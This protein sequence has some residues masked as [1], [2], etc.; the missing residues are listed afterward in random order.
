M[1][2]EKNWQAWEYQCHIP[3]HLELENMQQYVVLNDAS[4]PIGVATQKNMVLNAFSEWEG[5]KKCRSTHDL[6]HEISK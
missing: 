1:E 5:W 6:K 2:Y 4:N 3:D